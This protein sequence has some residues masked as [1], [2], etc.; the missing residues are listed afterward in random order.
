MSA[1]APAHSVDVLRKGIIVVALLGGVVL[2]HR[3]AAPTGADPRGLMAL[4][5]V[6]LAAYTIGELA[7]VLKLPH[8]TGYLLAGL[9]LGP[10]AAHELSHAFPGA[11]PP[12][13]DEGILSVRVIDQLS[14]LDTLALPLIALTAGGELHLD[15][16][17]KGLKPIL[18]V[19]AGQAVTLVLAFMGFALLVGGLLPGVGL[20]EMSAL[21][22]SQQLTVGMVLGALGLATSAAATIAIILGAGAKGPMTRT[23]LSVVVLKDV[24]VVVLFAAATAAAT[25][26]IGVGGEGGLSTALL[27]I[28]LSVVIGVAVGG[29]VH[30]Y[31]RFIGVERL[32][33]LVAL[34]YTTSFLCGVLH[35]EVALVFI[36]AGFVVAN[37]S[38][39]GEVLI[40]DVERLSLPVF[41][42][43]F[44]LAG[45]RLHID[46]IMQMA[47]YAALLV[48]VR[49]GATWAGVAVG[50][51][52][53]GADENTRKYGW[54]GMI[55]QAG[56]AISLAGQLPSL[57]PG[58][59]GEELFALV[60]AGVAVHEVI[61]PAMLQSAL[62]KAGEIPGSEV[63]ESPSDGGTQGVEQ[64]TVALDD[65]WGAPFLS[66][67][68][69]LETT[70]RE[71]EADL[72]T[73]AGT[74]AEGPVR[75]WAA[76]GEA[77]T[78]GLRR[79]FLRAHRRAAVL[80]RDEDTLPEAMVSQLRELE[81]A[82]R[83][84]LW[85]RAGGDPLEGLDPV[86]LIALI[87]QRLDGLPAS[88][89]IPV[90]VEALA[91]RPEPTLRKVLRALNRVW[92]RLA[93]RSRDIA[94]RDLFRY[95]VGGVA[96]GRLDG[97]YAPQVRADID[98]ARS[99]G[100]LFSEMARRWPR[101]GG[102]HAQAELVQLRTD[103]LGAL[104]TL[105]ETF[106]R[107]EHDAGR[108][109]QAVLGTAMVSAKR[110]LPLLG[111]V[112]L[113][114][115]SR[116]FSRVYSD[117]ND[118]VTALTVHLEAAR[119]LV[120]ARLRGTGAELE[121]AALQVTTGVAVR[122][123]AVGV[124]RLIEDLGVRPL[125]D[126]TASVAAI[127]EAVAS[128]LGT[129]ADTET[130]TCGRELATALR[131][132][133]RPAADDL[134]EARR[135]LERLADELHNSCASA[136]E[137]V[138]HDEVGR[139]T[140]SVEV[141]VGPVEVGDWSLPRPQ[142]LV[143][144]RLR[145]S[146]RS[147]LDSRVALALE[148]AAADA[149]AVIADARATVVD[150]DRVLAFNV[151]LAAA[152]LDVF[153]DR[154]ANED[155]RALV[156]EMVTGAVGRSHARVMR[157]HEALAALQLGLPGTIAESVPAIVEELAA[158]LI[159]GDIAAL[160]RLSLGEAGLRRELWR[161]AGSWGLPAPLGAGQLRVRLQS[162]LGSERWHSLAGM[163]GDDP[164][165]GVAVD[166]AAPPAHKHIPVVYGRLFTDQV[167]AAMELAPE[168]EAAVESA[169]RLLVRP[170]QPRGVA[171]IAGDPAMRAMLV[172]R[173][174]RALPGAVTQLVP[175]ADPPVLSGGGPL[176]VA[177]LGQWLRLVPGG[178][179]ELSH[180]VEHILA[181]QHPVVVAASPEVWTAVRRLSALGE[182]VG[183]TVAPG[184]LDPRELQ[185]AVLGRHAMS[186][187]S[188]RFDVDALLGFR[189]RRVLGRHE[190][191]QR[192]DRDAWFAHL[193]ARSGGRLSDAL[194][195]WMAA[196][197][198]VDEE[199]GELTVGPIPT[200]LPH[201]LGDIDDRDLLLL[202]RALQ[203][204]TVDGLGLAHT[205]GMTLG[206]ARGSLASLAAR[207]LLEHTEDGDFYAVPSH[208][209]SSVRDAVRARGWGA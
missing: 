208:L 44:T 60:L 13:F 158:D 108:R 28:G 105:T 177:D 179:A 17:K 79:A 73:M 42:V 192:T 36:A 24:A 9:L 31:L 117:R 15:E 159:R 169:R 104:E 7:E 151:E 162:L 26:A 83:S 172:E 120:S 195:L 61:G 57:F 82:W 127:L 142:P 43:F 4:G 116:R 131:D 207:M 78:L 37:F 121:V 146:V 16:L 118:A 119:S 129:S 80:A 11:L 96:V 25:A 6:I 137:A 155:T 168:R 206:Q 89:T 156:T 35:A 100:T 200:G 2:L 71:L 176:V 55:A 66:D 189:L 45:A 32:L 188:V 126:V 85:S 141:P 5:F 51:R 153:A 72:R 185:E 30:L 183:A 160:R 136:V 204:S 165:A 8:I 90:S 95:H 135:L 186:G 102:E 34:I 68:A 182:V 22:M 47:G 191:R 63:T 150:L 114:H 147:W 181:G 199:A 81:A 41:V 166:F 27:H 175:Q 115:W 97:T 187:Y 46:V 38:D 130:P 111:G 74:V 152:E 49:G 52:L 197:Q 54:M 163:L 170:D 110:E 132:A 173:L 139:V 62:G 3:Y 23:V 178:Q 103:V 123:R 33:F 99:V 134:D 149:L 14:L 21:S 171:V 194:R 205:S 12:P 180:L 10:S 174:V 48:A 59:L 69:D 154:L 109:T 18:G 65:P 125:R 58:G 190:Q 98:A 88:S 145:A 193:H 19:L 133:G 112:D 122:R 91:A 53:T 124:G 167:V 203:G 1:P 64:P 94:M 92:V 143:T 138:V 70:V 198:A 86:S 106:Q 107:A 56:L 202:R 201:H 50:G 76:E 161:T 184:P 113:P 20:P 144:L 196:V 75:A 101:G 128:V 140:D 93:G 39:Q 84:A 67:S 157:A 148:A 77:W 29:L 40:H 164:L 209:E 87:D